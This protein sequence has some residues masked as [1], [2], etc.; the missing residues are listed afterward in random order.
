MQK[1]K[2]PIYD[3]GLQVFYDKIVR[4][5]TVRDRLRK[6]LLEKIETERNGELVDR[7]LIKNILSM[8]V[9]LGVNSCVVY[10]E[11]FEKDFLEVTAQFYRME[12]QNYL[13]QNTCPDYLKKVITVKIDDQMSCFIFF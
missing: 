13:D 5:S 12:S 8:L 6:L 10:E 2:T 7:G 4:C 3:V 1:R 11:E 9:D